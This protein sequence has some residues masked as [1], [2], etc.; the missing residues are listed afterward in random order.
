MSTIHELYVDDTHKSRS[1]DQS[2]SLPSFVEHAVRASSV[3]LC[4]TIL[5]HLSPSAKQVCVWHVRLDALTTVHVAYGRRKSYQ[6]Q[7]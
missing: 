1:V 5:Q 6:S 2:V 7:L 4:H 3:E